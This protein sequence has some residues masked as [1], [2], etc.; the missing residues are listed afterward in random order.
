MRKGR[1]MRCS[2]S[3]AKEA[4]WEGLSGSLLGMPTGSHFPALLNT[5]F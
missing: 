3:M 4:V 5:H 1:K 2:S